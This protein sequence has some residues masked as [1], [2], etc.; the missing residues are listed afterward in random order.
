MLILDRFVL[1]AGRN[2]VLEIDSMEIPKGTKSLIIGANGTGKTLLLLALHGDYTSFQGHIKLQGENASDATRRRSTILIEN[3]N[4]LLP[5]ETVWKN[6]TL[7]LSQPTKRQF[8]KIEEMIFLADLEDRLYEP[9]ENLSQSGRK[10]VEL[11]RAVAQ[12]PCMIL[13]DDLDACF[14]DLN[15]V[16]AL[17]ICDIA[18]SGGTALLATARQPITDFPL[19]HRIQNKQLTIR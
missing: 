16:K 8:S 4:H 11:I 12:F 7:S 6:L 1:M 17:G 15:L 18:L 9:V 14:D 5:K 19:V 2:P 10:F 3:Q 13:M